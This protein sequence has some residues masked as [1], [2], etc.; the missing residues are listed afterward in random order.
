LSSSKANQ[1]DLH[2][3]H[4][5]SY[6]HLLAFS[7]WHLCCSRTWYYQAQRRSCH[8]LVVFLVQ[9]LEKWS[10]HHLDWKISLFA[11]WSHLHSAVTCSLLVGLNQSDFL[12]CPSWNLCL[13]Q[14]NRCSLSCSKM[15]QSK[16]DWWN[17]FSLSH[18]YWDTLYQSLRVVFLFFLSDPC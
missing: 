1:K 18:C 7:S 12:A 16:T 10:D 14:R 17:P 9:K 5:I 13:A 3:E 6:D 4:Q 15:A 2:D 11:F 8:H